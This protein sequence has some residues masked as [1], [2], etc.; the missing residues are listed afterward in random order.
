MFLKDQ[1]FISHDEAHSSLREEVLNFKE[2]VVP[3][4]GDLLLARIIIES[5]SFE[6]E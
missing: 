5:Q 3:C 4:D 1:E 2:E 6:L